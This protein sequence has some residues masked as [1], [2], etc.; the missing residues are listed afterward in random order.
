MLRTIVFAI[1]KNKTI[2]SFISQKGMS[3]GFAKRFVAGETLA[4]A[5]ILARDFNTRSITCSLNFLGEH[6][7]DRNRAEQVTQT[8]IDILDTIQREKVDSNLSVKPSQMGLDIDFQ[9]CL[10]NF[11]KVLEKAREHGNFVRVDMESSAYT[12]RTLDLLRKSRDSFQEVGTVI[13]S[14]LY[15]SEKDIR[16]LNAQ[17]TRVRLCKGAYLEPKEVAYPKKADVDASFM[18]LTE[19]LLLEGRYPALATH[20]EKMIEHARNFAVQRGIGKERYE[21]QMILGV[22]RDL[23]ESLRKEGHQV[24]IYIPFGK[25]WLPYFMRRLAERPANMLMVV[26]NLLAERRGSR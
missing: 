6:V 12:D 24:R 2:T 1:A 15:R 11:R 9:F 22:R 18:K 19:M 14:A 13:Q 7:S 20:D 25:E 21:F 3:T 17:G 16:E 5:I 23:Q 26:R 4:E 10:N 8:Y